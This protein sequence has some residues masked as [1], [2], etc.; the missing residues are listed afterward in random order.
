MFVHI[1]PFAEVK[2]IVIVLNSEFQVGANNRAAE[3]SLWTFSQ[4]KL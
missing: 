3:A 2:E 4:W 1:C